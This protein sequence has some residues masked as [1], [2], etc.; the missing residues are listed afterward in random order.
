MVN[1][2]MTDMFESLYCVMLCYVLSPSGHECSLILHSQI[3]L[4]FVNTVKCLVN[5]I[6]NSYTAYGCVASNFTIFLVCELHFYRV[7]V[8]WEAT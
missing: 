8:A 4:L 1:V 6:T 2:D 3:R 7:S 5:C